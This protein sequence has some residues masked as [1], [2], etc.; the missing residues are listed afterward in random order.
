MLVANRA[1]CGKLLG[2]REAVLLKI[3]PALSGAAQ[4]FV[5]IDGCLTMGRAEWRWSRL[6]GM[7]SVCVCSLPGGLQ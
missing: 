7:V 1:V 3:N 6:T 5:D 2:M 4:M